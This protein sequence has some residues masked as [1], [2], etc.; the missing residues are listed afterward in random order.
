MTE[1]EKLKKQI[2]RFNMFFELIYEY[3]DCSHTKEL[4]EITRYLKEKK[5]DIF[6]ISELTED[7]KKTMNKAIAMKF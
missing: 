2:K 7:E 3:G 4:T 1:L 6:L 5:K